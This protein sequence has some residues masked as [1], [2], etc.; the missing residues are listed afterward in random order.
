MLGPDSLELAVGSQCRVNLGLTLT[1]GNIA[2]ENGPYVV[3]LLVKD[4]DF[5]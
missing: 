5:P 4:G 1:S 3:D 2:I